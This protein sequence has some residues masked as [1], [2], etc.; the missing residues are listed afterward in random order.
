MEIFDATEFDLPE[1]AELFNQYRQFYH[2]P[3]AYSEC[4]AFIAQRMKQKD[5]KIYIARPNPQVLAGF[6][7]L[8]PL[9][10]SVR[11][12]KM[13]LL[14]DL[15]VHPDHRKNGI[16]SM[17]I[18]AAALLAADT[19]SCGLLL[20]TGKVNNEGNALYLKKGFVLNTE[21]N[22]YFLENKH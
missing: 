1:L 2:Q 15:F 6:I 22:F 12:K 7:Q 5:S 11:L 8:Y 19:H 10:S 13:W 16:A 17:L 21:S 18:D 3:D 20:E 4:M 9:F 14:N